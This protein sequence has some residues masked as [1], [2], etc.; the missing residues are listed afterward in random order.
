MEALIEI[1]D[2]DNNLIKPIGTVKYNP[3]LYTVETLATGYTREYWFKLEQYSWRGVEPRIVVTPLGGDGEA[4]ERKIGPHTVAVVRN[5][6]IKIIDPQGQ[7]K[8]CSIGDEC[9]VPHKGTNTEGKIVSVGCEMVYFDI[10]DGKRRW[11]SLDQFVMLNIEGK[12]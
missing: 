7:S 6:S 12:E 5:Q 1:R 8:I 4:T 9:R 3:E 2:Q 11:I 10:G